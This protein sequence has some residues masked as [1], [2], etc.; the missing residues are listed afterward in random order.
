MWTSVVHH[1]VN[2]HDFP[3]EVFSKCAHPTLTDD[4]QRRKKWLISQS[5]AHTALKEVVLNK[6]LLKDIRQLNEFCHTGNLEVYHSLL[7]KYCPK[8][9]EFDFSQMAARTVL[10]VLDH[11][12]NSERQQKKT[13]EGKQCFKVAYTKNSA[14]W[15]IKPAYDV[16]T[17]DHVCELMQSAVQQQQSPCVSP[18]A[19]LRRQN[20]APIVAPPRH[21]LLSQHLS[22]FQ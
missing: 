13:S 15:V 6:G 22:R 16:K 10:A 8:R 12:N 2:V 19:C 9:Q 11:N 1:I 20:I 21:E 7:T 5:A 3:G 17:Y 4:E 18:V 14:K